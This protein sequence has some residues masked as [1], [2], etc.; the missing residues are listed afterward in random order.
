MSVGL[1]LVRGKKGEFFD[2]HDEPDIVAE[3]QR[4]LDAKAETDTKTWR[5]VPAPWGSAELQAELVRLILLKKLFQT[6]SN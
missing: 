1:R 2:R 5:S 6:L 3:R 4:Y